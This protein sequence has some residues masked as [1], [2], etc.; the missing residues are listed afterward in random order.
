MLEKITYLKLVMCVFIAGSQF[1]TQWNLRPFIL[2]KD[3]FYSWEKRELQQLGI[4]ST[5]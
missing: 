5:L 1:Y 4:C 3:Y 2:I